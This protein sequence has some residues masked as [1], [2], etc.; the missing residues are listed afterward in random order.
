MERKINY[1]RKNKN[2]VNS[3]KQDKKQFVNMFGYKLQ[4][5]SNGVLQSYYDLFQVN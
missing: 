1:L 4:H 3:L 5:F 2:D